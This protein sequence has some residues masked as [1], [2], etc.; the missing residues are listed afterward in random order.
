M[1][2]FLYGTLMHDGLMAALAGPGGGS[3]VPATLADHAVDRVAGAVYPMLVARAGAVTHGKFWTGLTADQLQRLDI[4]ETAFGYDRR[5][6]QV[7]TINGAT[8]A[9]TAYFP[10]PDL[11][12]GGELWD[13]AAWESAAAAQNLEAAT[14]IAAFDPPLDPD[15]LARQWPMIAHRAE[16]R[17]RG[18]ASTAPATLRQNP[19]PDNAALVAPPILH[20][21]FFRFAQMRL[22]HRRFDGQTSDTLLRE[23]F[24]A[25]DAVMVLPYDA[26]R[27][28]I[29]LVEQFR[30]G[31]FMRSDPNPW[32]L[33]PVAGIVDAG[34]T[35][36]DCAR[37]EALEEAG[38]TITTLERM[39]SFYPSPGS[40]TDYFYCYLAPVDL[41]DTGHWHG[42]LASENEDL[43]LHVI[44][45]AAAIGL[46]ASGEIT[47]GPL[48]TMLY[49]L[50][51]HRDR[52]EFASTAP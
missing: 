28:R 15:A 21:N 2:L 31:P 35:P 6:V 38:L 8:H 41:P 32:S 25:V 13:Y 22:R 44:D 37:R 7:M 12:S 40:S 36:E 46:I 9:A 26:S 45:R 49:W 3:G 39:F 48:I 27:D 11:T 43:R 20:G 34:E 14:E 42:G 16:A 33:E 50:A 4:Y 51:A 5:A 29:L 30:A 17:L 47:A 19:G 23:I 52:L 24:V 10:P 18:R 1:G